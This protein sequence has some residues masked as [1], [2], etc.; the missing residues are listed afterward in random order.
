MGKSSV[1][2]SCSE[3]RTVLGEIKNGLIHGLESVPVLVTP[4]TH[5]DS[6]ICQI[7]KGL[8]YLHSSGIIHGDLRAVSDNSTRGATLV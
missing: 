4:F 5:D 7:A 6:Q 1:Y 2:S 8:A 3:R